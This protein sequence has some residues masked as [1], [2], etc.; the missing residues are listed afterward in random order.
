MRSSLADEAV[1]LGANLDPKQRS[2]L[3]VEMVK[4]ADGLKRLRRLAR[5]RLAVKKWQSK[6]REK[7]RI[8]C[9]K[10]YK[11]NQ[12]KR[13]AQ[14]K[15]SVRRHRETRRKW[16]KLYRAVNGDK[17]REY[18]RK[19]RPVWRAKQ[20][21]TNPEY[22]LKDRMRSCLKRGLNNQNLKKTARTEAMVG[23]TMAHLRAHI[24]GQFLPGMSWSDPSSYSIDHIIPLYAFN[25]LD[26]EELY[27]SFNWRNLRP[28]PL[29]ENKSKH[30][31]VPLPLPNWLPFHIAT[32]IILRS[33]LPKRRQH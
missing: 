28:L 29:L 9:N 26:K 27:W 4:A 2:K 24:E 16:S 31:K 11:E 33:T 21:A 32:R 5:C 6:N 17:I 20:M 30:A 13:L 25:L 10:Y 1:R 8:D 3:R 18:H 19:Y 23:C 12:P 22:V 15:A 14:K 7:R